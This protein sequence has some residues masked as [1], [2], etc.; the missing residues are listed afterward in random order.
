MG[1][2]YAASSKTPVQTRTN[3]RLDW[4]KPQ[5]KDPLL[6]HALQ[7]HD[8]SRCSSFKG[9]TDAH[10]VRITHLLSAPLR[11][12]SRKHEPWRDR[13][14]DQVAN[15]A[16]ACA[17]S[18]LA[19]DQ[20]RHVLWGH[21]QQGNHRAMPWCPSPRL[22]TNGQRGTV[23]V[24]ARGIFTFPCTSLRVLRMGYETSKWNRRTMCQL[25]W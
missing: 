3:S 25:P 21:G 10:W 20:Q 19:G 7:L 13:D 6:W 12:P 5:S 24:L 11:T 23:V 18:R 17:S 1:L 22:F 8:R 2:Q 16:N 9:Q 4:S 15:V 14:V